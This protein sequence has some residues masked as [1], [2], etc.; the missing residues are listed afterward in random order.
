M[1]SRALIIGY[2]LDHM[3]MRQLIWSTISFLVNKLYN[4]D[5]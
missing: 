5:F 4:K 3:Y 2:F 1:Y